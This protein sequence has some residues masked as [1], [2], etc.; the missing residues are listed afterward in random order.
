MADKAARTCQDQI[1]QLEHDIRQAIPCWD[2]RQAL[3][4]CSVAGY[5]GRAKLCLVWIG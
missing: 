1:M 4:L 3:Y 5:V 2:E